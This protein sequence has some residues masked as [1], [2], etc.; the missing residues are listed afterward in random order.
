M[1]RSTVFA[2][3]ATAFLCGTLAAPAGA[4]TTKTTIATVDAETP[5]SAGDGWLVWSVPVAGGWALDAYHHGTVSQLPVA[6][7][8][9]PFDASVGTNA[10]GAPVVTFSRCPRTPTMR[11]VGETQVKGGALLEPRSGTGCRIHVL[12]FS[13]EHET[14]PAIPDPAGTSDTTPAMWHGQVTFA[15]R[16]PGHGQV[17]QIMS[18]LPQTPRRVVTLRH[19]AIPSRCPGESG[20]CT[21]PAHG[22][23]EA[24]ARNGQ[25]VTFLWHVESPGVI[26][27]G[28][29]EVRVDQLA[30]GRSS[31]AAAGF[32]HEACTG[33]LAPG[34][35]EYVWP[36]PPVAASRTVLFAQLEGFDCFTGFGSVLGSYLAGAERASSGKFANTVLGLAKEGSTLYALVPGPA[37]A[38]ADS[39]SCAPTDPCSLERVTEPTLTLQ[40]AAPTP[41]FSE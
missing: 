31:L 22:E 2:L 8:P 41:P 21:R 15:R 24:L 32:G 28:A 30:S 11:D 25:I 4:E 38:G 29:W 36:E 12:T 23:V 35:L 18:W 13:S 6:T 20:D 37:P 39:P 10:A 17:W 26:G 33:P 9:Q 1:G 19:G 14:R 5:I 34:E 7:R 27:E 40:P 16:A 3:V